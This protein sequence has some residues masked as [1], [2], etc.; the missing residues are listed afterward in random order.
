MNPNLDPSQLGLRD[1]HLPGDIGLWPLAMGWWILALA[2]VGWLV[3]LSLR[4][5]RY[6][7]HRETC[8]QL[9]RAIKAIEAGADPQVF[10]P[11]VSTTLRRFAMTM[12]Q[13]SAVVAGLVGDRWLSYLDSCWDRSSFSSGAGRLLLSSPYREVNNEGADEALELCRMGV[14]WVQSQPPRA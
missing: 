3:F 8:R 14:D 7:R 9:R 13:D 12:A 11:E 10:I 4:H 5:F 6:R 1:I 2:A